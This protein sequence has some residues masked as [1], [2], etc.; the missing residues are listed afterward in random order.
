MQKFALNNT[1]VNKTASL[2]ISRGEHWH[3]TTKGREVDSDSPLPTK[4]CGDEERDLSG[5]RFGRFSV[6][7]KSKDVKKRWVVRCD[8]GKYTLRRSKAILN[9]SNQ[10]DRCEAC[11]ELAYQKRE[12][13][14]RRT[15]KDVDIR[16][17]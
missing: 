5:V 11:K 1:P 6:I 7:G 13:F 8:C 10:Q 12:E 15:G 4:P 3:P 17:F 9:E 14:R 2:V 16:K